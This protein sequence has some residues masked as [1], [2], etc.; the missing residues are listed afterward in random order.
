MESVHASCPTEVIAAPIEV[1]WDLVTH[2]EGW[3]RFYDIR[4]L[5]VEPA[6]RAAL[7]QR[8]TAETGPVFL[9]LKVLLEFVSIDE[10][11]HRIGVSVRLPFGLSV[12]EDMECGR[13]SADKCRVNYRCNFGFPGGWRGGALRLLLRR[14]LQ[15]GPADSLL[16][17]KIAAERR[18]SGNT[19]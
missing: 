19:K 7:G 11:H 1:V 9:H 13:I 6:G 2:P 10:S 17:L 4:I 18:W 16:R 14:E 15:T 8:I 3:G 5:S 12:V